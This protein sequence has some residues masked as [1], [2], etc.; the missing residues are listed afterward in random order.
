MNNAPDHPYLDRKFA[1]KRGRNGSTISRKM[2]T[3]ILLQPG[4]CVTVT[5]GRKDQ[6]YRQQG[7]EEEWRSVSLL[8]PWCCSITWKLSGWGQG[9]KHRTQQ[10][11]PCPDRPW[12]MQQLERRKNLLDGRWWKLRKAAVK[13]QIQVEEIAESRGEGTHKDRAK[14]INPKTRG[15][16]N[17][18]YSKLTHLKYAHVLSFNNNNNNSLL[19]KNVHH[20]SF[21]KYQLYIYIHNA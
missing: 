9:S 20:T 18:T 13:D 19:K 15:K 4:E 17:A 14:K 7:G 21:H 1:E 8:L 10:L 6:H 16:E 12:Q 2:L 11:H 5:T 3:E